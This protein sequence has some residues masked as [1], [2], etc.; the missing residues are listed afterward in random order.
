MAR[1]QRLRHL[2]NAVAARSGW[3]DAAEASQETQLRAHELLAHD[4]A[5][6][7]LSR[8]PA[9][10]DMPYFAE[11]E[12]TGIPRT[13]RPCGADLPMVWCPR[14]GASTDVATAGAALRELI[15]RELSG[16]GAL[17]IRNLQSFGVSDAKDFSQLT[18]SF[19]YDLFECVTLALVA[20]LS[21]NPHLR[22]TG[23]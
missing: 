16:A 20:C 1:N 13:L 15:D 21:G 9:L 6:A 3:P 2:R 19:G 12:S 18:A 4:G 11:S 22:P 17:L 5:G 8:E 14:P 23:R 10:R 7:V